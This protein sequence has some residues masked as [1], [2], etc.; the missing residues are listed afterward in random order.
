MTA[1]RAAVG[2]VLGVVLL[3]G[4]R[5]RHPGETGFRDSFTD[6]FSREDTRGETGVAGIGDDFFPLGAG[7]TWT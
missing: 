4:C 5:F 2:S 3:A 7:W 6:S 1:L